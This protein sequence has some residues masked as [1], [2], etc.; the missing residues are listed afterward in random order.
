M[1][2]T[3]IMNGTRT[4]LALSRPENEKS[5]TIKISQKDCGCK[6]KFTVTE[7]VACQL[8]MAV[9]GLLLADVEKRMFILLM[10]VGTRAGIV[11]PVISDNRTK[12]SS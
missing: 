3:W 4:P 5:E 12:D 2:V 10:V 9:L 7:K 11:L 6:M 1:G 8:Y